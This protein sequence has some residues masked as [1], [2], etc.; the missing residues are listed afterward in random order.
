MPL[1]KIFPRKGI[2]PIPSLT[3]KQSI[4]C[5]PRERRGTARK[6]SQ[7]SPTKN[8]T[9]REAPPV[10]QKAGKKM[11]AIDEWKRNVRKKKTK[12]RR[13]K[14]DVRGRADSSR[15]ARGPRADVVRRSK[16]G[17]GMQGRA[18]TGSGKRAL[19]NRIRESARLLGRV[20]RS[21]ETRKMTGGR[22]TQIATRAH[23]RV[24]K[25]TDPDRAGR[26]DQSRSTSSRKSNARRI[27]GAS[28][29]R[30]PGTR[31][32]KAL[33]LTESRHPKKKRGES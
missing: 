22:P 3:P 7:Q 23:Y 30:R 13:H 14:N 15:R 32:W 10:L 20:E 9:R 25:K 24:S 11:E 12:K 33:L 31:G 5:L 6:G 16:E 27:R 18:S 21:G 1:Q 29:S 17:E 28:R 4:C 26:T 2:L 19:Q 8:A